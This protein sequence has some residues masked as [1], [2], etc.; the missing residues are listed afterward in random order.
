MRTR[1]LDFIACPQCE[2]NL[3]LT[4][5]KEEGEQILEGSLRCV[6]CANEY[7][8]IDG[9]PRLLISDSVPEEA[10]RTVERFGQEWQEFDS[11]NE[12]YEQQ[13][14]DWIAPN[15]PETFRDK[16]VLE[17][18]CGKG[19]HSRLAAQFGAQDVIAI[20]LGSAVDV[21]F[22]NTREHPNVHIVQG[23][24][25]RLPVARESVDVAFSVGVLHHTVAPGDAFACLATR[26]KPGGLIFAWVYGAEN[27]EWITRYV[28]P[29]R[30]QL[31]S[32][33]PHWATYEL[34]R[35]PAGMLW[36]LGKALYGPTGPRFGFF[37]ERLPIDTYLSYVSKFPFEEI[38][39]IVHDHL[40]P[41]IAHYI[42]HEEFVS[43][44]SKADLREV[45]IQWHNENS[46]RGTG[47]KPG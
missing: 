11:L 46:W 29:I 34:S 17:G 43:W 14:L 30:K 10:T 38:H 12:Q 35:V 32:R 20:D 22:R 19:R 6:G 36:S 13:F 47:V 2:K 5:L 44:F 25:F 33:L 7:P 28:D 9:V 26:V 45:A 41:P 31:T 16:V 37:S 21:A 39:T 3:S 23:D 40:T 15:T 42:P 8:I 18:G 24:L 4:V 27:N 1:L